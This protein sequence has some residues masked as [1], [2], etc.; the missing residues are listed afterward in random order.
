MQTDP[1]ELSN[2]QSRPK[3]HAPSKPAEEQ[4]PSTPTLGQL[5]LILHDDPANTLSETVE[6]LVRVA[7]RSF[8]EA[9]AIAYQAHKHGSTPLLQTHREHAEVLI[10]QLGKQNLTVSI[11]GEPLDA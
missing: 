6:A 7:K 11:D 2:A 4:A 5:T 1:T 3:S 9:S 8:T 10:Q